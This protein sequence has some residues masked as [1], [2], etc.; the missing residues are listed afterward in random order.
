ML[1]TGVIA[2]DFTGA[3]DIASGYVRRGHRAVVVTRLEAVPS[4]DDDTD[5]VVVALKT[6]TAD[7]D[8]AVAASRSAL[9]ALRAAACERFVFKYCSTFDSTDRGNIGPVLDALADDLGAAR[10]VVAPAFPENG[11]TVQD[12]RLYV[13][14]DLL[15]DSSMR[16]HPLTPMTRS[17]V[18]DLLAPQTDAAVDELPITTVRGPGL[19]SAIATA[20][21]RYVV[22]D[23]LEDDD[24]V[25]VGMATADHVLTSGSAGI[26]LGA[27]PGTADATAVVRSLTGRRLVVCGSASART[28]EQV[29]HARSSGVPA[30][31]L[32]ATADDLVSSTSA[33]LRARYAEDD[34]AVPVVHTVDHAGGLAAGV[35]QGALARTLADIVAAAVAE[36]D[37]RNLIIAGGETS[38]AVVGRLGVDRLVIGPS[39]APGVCWSR[40]DVGATPIA[41]ALKSGNFGAVDMFTNAWEAAR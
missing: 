20:R 5:V 31:L 1:R 12:G 4:V 8:D 21:G 38:G 13:G 27:E 39:I 36:L 30:L 6:R 17:R 28:R 23:T 16:H 19:R 35:D 11:R 14:D 41:I 3:T 24:L 32:D 9:T 7:V 37:V 10:V 15:E 2:D 29:A 40:T 18:R 22:V 33:W 25:A 34:R 26:A